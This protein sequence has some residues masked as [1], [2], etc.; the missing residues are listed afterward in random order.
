VRTNVLTIIQ[1]KKNWFRRLLRHPA[2]CRKLDGAIEL[3]DPHGAIDDDVEVVLGLFWRVF[4]RS[5]ITTVSRWCRDLHIASPCSVCRAHGRQLNSTITKSC[6]L[7]STDQAV[8]Q[9]A[10]QTDGPTDGQHYSPIQWRR[11]WQGKGNCPIPPKF[12]AV[13]KFS[14]TKSKFGDK[15]SPFW[16]KLWSKLEFW[17]P[18]IFSVRKLQLLVPPTFLLNPRRRWS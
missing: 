13:G 14:S 1:N 9:T 16:K 5:S 18:I 10:R 7:N 17:T 2:T 15:I 3:R 6:S 11:A 4:R 12:K 8:S